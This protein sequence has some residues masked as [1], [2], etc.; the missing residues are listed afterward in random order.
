MPIDEDDLAEVDLAVTNAILALYHAGAS[1]SQAERALREHVEIMF[2]ALDEFED[3]SRP[4]SEPIWPDLK[5]SV[6]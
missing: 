5:K 3:A 2:D 4:P 1:R 6:H